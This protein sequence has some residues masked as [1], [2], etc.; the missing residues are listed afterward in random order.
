M[1]LLVSPHKGPVMQSFGAFFML[2]LT[3]VMSMQK[4]NVRGQRS[5]SQR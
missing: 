3:K 5:R 4:V 1:S 2:S